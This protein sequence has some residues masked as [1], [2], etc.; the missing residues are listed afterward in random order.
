MD[1]PF[2]FCPPELV[3]ETILTTNHMPCKE[4]KLNP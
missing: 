1:L 4:F 3:P 2:I